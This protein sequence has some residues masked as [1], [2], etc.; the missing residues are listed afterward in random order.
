[1]HRVTVEDARDGQHAHFCS[2]VTV[3]QVADGLPGHRLS[4]HDMGDDLPA[5][6]LDPGQGDTPQEGQTVRS[7]TKNVLG[8]LFWRLP[9]VYRSG[10]Q[11]DGAE[12]IGDRQLVCPHG[13]E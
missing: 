9:V 1:M 4:R 12:E 11:H 5:A 3:D 6:P 10:G 2:R 13:D 8:G 7:A